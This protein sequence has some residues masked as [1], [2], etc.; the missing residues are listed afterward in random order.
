MLGGKCIHNLALQ[1]TKIG[2]AI[3]CKIYI[4]NQLLHFWPNGVCGELERMNCMQG[5]LHQKLK[6]LIH[7]YVVIY[8]QCTG[9]DWLGHFVLCWNELHCNMTVC[10]ISFFLEVI[11]SYFYTFIF[12]PF[13]LSELCMLKLNMSFIV[14]VQC[15]WAIQDMGTLNIYYYI[16][17][18]VI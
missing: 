18:Y 6:N 9:S 2:T 14:I 11:R 1:F 7:A 13:Y 17:Y 12:Y 3:A 16:I 8:A 15:L 4:F 5:F 10:V